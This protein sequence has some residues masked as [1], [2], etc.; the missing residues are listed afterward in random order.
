M[1]RESMMRT[2]TIS[3]GVGVGPAYSS[4]LVALS[5]ADSGPQVML[6]RRRRR[7]K[8]MRCAIVKRTRRSATNSSMELEDEDVNDENKVRGRWRN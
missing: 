8:G 7:E 3:M 6:F 2:M 4:E 5:S 1:P